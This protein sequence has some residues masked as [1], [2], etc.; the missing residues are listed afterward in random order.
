LAG[1]EVVSRVGLVAFAGAFEPP[2]AVRT[3]SVV[4][5]ASAGAALPAWD[6]A[7]P[8]VSAPGFAAGGGLLSGVF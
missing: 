1:C 2:R 8:A 4:R 5:D 7:F 3:A 6:L